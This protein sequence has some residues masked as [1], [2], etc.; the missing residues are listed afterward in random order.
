MLAK[1]K[2]LPVRLG[3]AAILPSTQTMPPSQH[4]HID[5]SSADGTSGIQNLMN[6]ADAFLDRYSMGDM[7]PTSS[8]SW[9]SFWVSR[10]IR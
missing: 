10:R 4:D 9:K 8:T 2:F 7:N 1:L 5:F 6:M 3:A